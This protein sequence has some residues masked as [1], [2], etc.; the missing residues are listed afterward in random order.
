MIFDITIVI[1][2]TPCPYNTGNLIDKCVYSDCSTNLLF[3]YLS[4]CPWESLFLVTQFLG[5]IRP[6]NNPKLL[7]VQVK[8]RVTCLL[9]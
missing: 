9:V 7:S 5:E 3:S 8:G 4:H 1:I 2:L 6:V